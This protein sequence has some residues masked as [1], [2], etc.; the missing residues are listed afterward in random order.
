MMKHIDIKKI[1]YGT[2]IAGTITMVLLIVFEDNIFEQFIVTGAI[3]EKCYDH[4][5][6]F[7]S[8]PLSCCKK[9]VLDKKNGYI[10]FE[11]LES[12][13]WTMPAGKITSESAS[14]FYKY[15]HKR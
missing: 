7:K 10:Q 5:T 6:P 15:N 9:R 14:Y 13:W 8:V 11:V 3:Y 12:D 2:I 4:S 1:G